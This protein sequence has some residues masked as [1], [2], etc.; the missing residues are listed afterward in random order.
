MDFKQK[1]RLK[2]FLDG[3]HVESIWNLWGSVKYRRGVMT[4]RTTPEEIVVTSPLV[5]GS[6]L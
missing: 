4:T 2:S 1:Y 3:V 6:T 5:M